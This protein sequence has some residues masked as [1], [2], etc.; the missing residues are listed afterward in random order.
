M[1]CND[2][3]RNDHCYHAQ[4]Y[5]DVT[6]PLVARRLVLLGSLNLCVRLFRI[7]LGSLHILIGSQQ[8]LALLSSLCLQ[9]H[10]D[11]PD[12]RHQL[13]RIV[14][15]LLPFINNGGHVIRLSRNFDVTLINKSQTQ[16]LLLLL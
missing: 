1:G 6:Q 14:K 3:E 7:R 5:Q 16:L 10:G 4:H 13:R 11:L 2:K 12:V 8:H 9:R 15:V